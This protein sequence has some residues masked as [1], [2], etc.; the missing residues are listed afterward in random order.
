MSSMPGGGAVVEPIP[1]VR[2]VAVPYG[3][4]EAFSPIV[5][6][7]MANNPGKFTYHGTGTYLIGRGEVAAI[8]PG[9]ADPLHVEALLAA[10]SPGEHITHIVI[11]HTHSDHSGASTMLAG[12]TGAVTYGQGPHG[13]VAPDDPD[14]VVRF[15]DPEA[16]GDP[17]A[18]S[19][20]PRRPVVGLIEGPDTSF[21]P[22]EVLGQGDCVAGDGWTLRAHHTPG[23]TSNHL[24]FELLEDRTLFTGDHVM[25][26][27]TSVITPPDGTLAA[28][29]TSLR[30]VAEIDVDRLR[31]THGPAVDDH[32]AF[33]G[34]LVAHRLRRS[35]QI[36]EA[37]ESGPATIAEL[38]PKI[39]CDVSKALWRPA[40]ASMEAHLRQLVDDGAVDVEP[41]FRRTA[42]FAL[43]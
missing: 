10:L 42:R 6:R 14:D 17:L 28:Y 1:F 8:D 31:P 21:Q 15:D 3:R 26:W 11:T 38:V 9:P 37:L 25:G 20:P 12:R 40:A 41:P 32:R 33:I 22:D 23:H 7:V 30:Q 34:A 19:R 4:P 16:D 2:E 35:A 13:Q 18:R 29:L 36:L 24:C 27:S 39:Y 5:R 43:A